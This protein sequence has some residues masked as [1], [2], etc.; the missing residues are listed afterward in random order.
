MD[1]NNFFYFIDKGKFTLSSGGIFRSKLKYFLLL[2]PGVIAAIAGNDAGGVATYSTIGAEYGYKLLWLLLLLLPALTVVQII[3]IRL[4]IV[5]GKGLTAL[6]REE[7]SLKPAMFAIV[8]LFISN[9]IISVSEFF[10]IAAAFELLGIPRIIGIPIVGL[11]VWWLIVKG[12]YNRVEKVFFILSAF[13]L[14][15]IA[16]AIL[17]KPDWGQVIYHLGVPSVEFDIRYLGLFIAT[18]A[19]SIT[20]YMQIYAQSSVVEKGVSVNNLKFAQIDAFIGSLFAIIIAMF[21]VITT[22][23]TLFPYGIKVETAQD[24][25]LALKPLAGNYSSILFAL[26]LLGASLLAA[27]VLPLTTAFSTSE[28]FGWRAGVNYSY[29]QA[30][31]FYSIFTILILAGVILSVIPGI[32]LFKLLVV[33]YLL[34]GFLLPVEFYYLLKLSNNKKLMGKHANG[35]FLNIFSVLVFIL[36]SIAIVLFM[37]SFFS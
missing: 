13:F 20:P 5:S 28:A 29:K 6:I 34:N 15:Y 21:I 32:P 37:F 1:K 16:S 3:S 27:G 10:G 30:P 33:A 25:A 11:T 2:G 17:A 14:S 23:T 12:T 26:G 35:L 9:A 8:I 4:G 19:T 31:I 24:A 22:G 7:F 18:I 36:V